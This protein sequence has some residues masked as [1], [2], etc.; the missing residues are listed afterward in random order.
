M[1]TKDGAEHQATGAKA[2][3]LDGDKDGEAMPRQA[4]RDPKTGQV[5]ETQVRKTRIPE[6]TLTNEEAAGITTRVATNE[7]MALVTPADRVEPM[8]SIK[9]AREDRGEAMGEAMVR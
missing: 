7:A 5:K 9:E 3:I 6:E 2:L 1:A 8:A 4:T